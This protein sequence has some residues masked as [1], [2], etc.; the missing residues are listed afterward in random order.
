MEQLLC[1]HAS[2]FRGAVVTLLKVVANLRLHPHD[3]AYR[4]L[5][6]STKAFQ[7]ALEPTRGAI[8]CLVAIGFVYGEGKGGDAGGRYAL[9]DAVDPGLLAEA[10]E[11]LRALPHEYEQ[12]AARQE[13]EA[14]RGLDALRMVSKLNRQ[15]RTR[16]CGS[17]LEV[18]S[19]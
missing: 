8:A 6:C 18:A 14:A 11:Q 16:A 3:E 17:S 13:E 19:C 5:R 10:E 2:L 15:T 7:S 4:A 1:N 12:R 9:G